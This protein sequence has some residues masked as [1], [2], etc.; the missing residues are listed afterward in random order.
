MYC[1]WLGEGSSKVG[2][3]GVSDSRRGTS[4]NNAVNGSEINESAL[5]EFAK[6]VIERRSS[7]TSDSRC[8]GD[9]REFL[10]QIMDLRAGYKT[11][12]D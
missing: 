5:G 7:V 3:K 10:G 8:V 1:S 9:T 12:E 4:I 6:S 11:I 2:G